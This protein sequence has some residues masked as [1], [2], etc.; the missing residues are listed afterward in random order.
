MKSNLVI[1]SDIEFTQKSDGG[2]SINVV[3]PE[4]GA[5][6]TTQQPGMEAGTQLQTPQQ[7]SAGPSMGQ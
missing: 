2:V 7:P 4:G 1:T 5:E 6:P 3:T